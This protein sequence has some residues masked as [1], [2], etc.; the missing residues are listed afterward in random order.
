MNYS[1]LSI[2]LTKQLNKTYK[3]NNGIFFTHPENVSITIKQ[4]EKYFDNI[5]VLEPSCGSCEYITKLYE[6]NNN[7]TPFLI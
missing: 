4:I 6:T 3:N 7:F 2:N 5:N 1:E